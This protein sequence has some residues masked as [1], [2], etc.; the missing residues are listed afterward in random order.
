MK[1]KF[2]FLIL[3]SLAL[4]FGCSSKK[5]EGKDANNTNNETQVKN[6]LVGDQI[7]K[8]DLGLIVHVV[9][10]YLL[11]KQGQDNND[12]VVF[13]V[14]DL[15]DL[16]FLGNVGLRGRQGPNT[17]YGVNYSGQFYENDG[18]YIIWVNDPPKFRISA[19]NITQS[20][21]KKETVIERYIQHDPEL[22]FMNALFV[23]DLVN[24]AGNQPGFH[25]G[26]NIKPLNIYKDGE[27]S[28]YGD[29]PLVTNSDKFP[30]WNGG[31]NFN[32]VRL[33][34]KPDESRFAVGMLHYDR[35]DILDKEGEL[36]NSNRDVENYKTYDVN[37]IYYSDMAMKEGVKFYYVGAYATNDL[38]FTLY[39]DVKR[40]EYE[41]I[42][43]TI[44]RVFDWDG[45]LKHELNCPDHLWNISVDEENGYLYGGSYTQE[46]LMRYNIKGY[47]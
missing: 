6:L 20:L 24:L 3:M 44:I 27:L 40:V 32:S 28:S 1:H 47:L 35:L 31:R 4:L 34:M 7:L 25:L 2:F 42:Y 41:G 36:I 14:Y 13:K 45:N 18:D 17:F 5:S 8:D 37:D 43:P 10:P 15:D 16:S 46:K 30:E 33:I 29:Y 38:L 21:K 26:S 39:Y 23:V 9:G 22:D 12:K 11:T 19:I